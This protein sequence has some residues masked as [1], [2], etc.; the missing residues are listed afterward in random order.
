MLGKL[1]I[2]GAGLCFPLQDILKGQTILGL[3]DRYS[4][5]LSQV[6]IRQLRNGHIAIVLNI[7][8]CMLLFT[9]DRK[10]CQQNLH[11]F[12]ALCPL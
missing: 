9:L 2:A 1:E 3:P 6:L 7:H 11:S 4:L 5:G 10:R 12:S 8:P